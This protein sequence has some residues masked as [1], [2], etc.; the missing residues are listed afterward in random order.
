MSGIKFAALPEIDL[1]KMHWP[2]EMTRLSNGSHVLTPKYDYDRTTPDD[3]RSLHTVTPPVFCP[4]G[5]SPFKGKKN[6]NE[7]S[8]T[9][10]SFSFDISFWKMEDRPALKQLYDLG[11]ALDE[12]LLTLAE[13]NSVAWFG[14][15]KSREVLLEKFNPIIRQPDPQFAPKMKVHANPNKKTGLFDFNV[16]DEETK[17]QLPWVDAVIDK[18]TGRVIH[19]GHTIPLSVRNYQGIKLKNVPL[20][21]LL[22]FRWVSFTP[23]SFGWSVRVRQVVLKRREVHRIEQPLIMGINYDDNGNFTNNDEI[24]KLAIT[25]DEV[26][27]MC[28]DEQACPIPMASA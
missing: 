12:Q 27:D 28:D 15:Q 19:P 2:E 4:F 7:D 20:I 25:E 17:H 23:M 6:A 22:E 14:K 1:T 9:I 10:P 21:Q 11:R 16:Y 26:D 5:L 24:N 3:W 8:T 13:K 18:E